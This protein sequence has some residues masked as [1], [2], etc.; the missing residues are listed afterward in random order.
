[1]KTRSYIAKVFMTLLLM[2]AF[3]TDAHS[4][5]LKKLKKRAEKAAER[6]VERRVDRETQEKTD[7]VLDSI[8]EPG[9]KGQSQGSTP[10]PPIGDGNNNPN[11]SNSG[12]RNSSGNNSSSPKSLTF[13]T[14][15][16]FVPGDRLIL[17][18]DFSVDNLGDF[19]AKWNTNG[20]GEVVTLNYS[21][22]KWLKLSDR[23]TYI[24]DLPGILPNDYTLE[25]D[26]M[27]T[28]LDKKVSS[29]ARLKIVLDDNNSLK[30]GA[31][32]AEMSIPMA[33]YI[34]A[35]VYV[36]NYFNGQN[37]VR[38]FIKKDVRNDILEL[39]HV[40]IA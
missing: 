15:Y 34:D 1:M 13:Y 17:Y 18:D 8:L 29:T 27:T 4:Q 3:S 39:T 25:F 16:D 11:T 35:G 36:N 12:E 19:P 33:Q 28:G 14:N 10:Q 20:S 26:M 38:N 5:I 32:Y 37:T 7:E 24:P 23:T 31:N 40:A 21:P 22:Y 30:R 6:T 9:S 2:T